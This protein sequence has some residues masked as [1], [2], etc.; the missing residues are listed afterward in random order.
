MVIKGQQCLQIGDIKIING[1][2]LPAF[3]AQASQ[4]EAKI[5]NAVYTSRRQY[6]LPDDAIVYCNFNQLYKL[7]PNTMSAWCNILKK[8]PDAVIWL[9]R[10]PALG[11]RH[12]HDWCWRLVSTTLAK[13]LTN[14]SCSHHNIP[15][16]RIIFSP[17]AAKEEHVRRGQ[18]ADVCLDTPLCKNNL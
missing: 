4:G 10:F 1:L 2:C 16:E 14:Y 3:E 13:P 9:L 8:V 11:E 7:D 12:V 15:K 17:V 6:G 5:Q 18:L